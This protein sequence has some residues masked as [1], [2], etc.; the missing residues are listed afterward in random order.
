MRIDTKGWG[1]VLVREDGDKALSKESNVTGNILRL[2]NIRD[3]GG[4]K[5]CDPS[6][7]G[8]TACKQGV[9]N[10]KDNHVYW[11]DRYALEDAHKAFNQGSVFYAE[12][13]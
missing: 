8:L 1:I 10:V 7:I 13:Y 6:T 3:N 5:R 12:T 2:L 9:I 4:W 11:H